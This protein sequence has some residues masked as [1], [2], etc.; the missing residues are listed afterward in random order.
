MDKKQAYELGRTHAD[1]CVSCSQP[2]MGRRYFLASKFP[3]E[4]TL[5]TIKTI[6]QHLAL[7]VFNSKYQFDA[8]NSPEGAFIAY[9]VG[10]CDRIDDDLKILYGPR[11]PN[12]SPA[13]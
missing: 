4:C 11:R 6:H 10:A 5:E 7:F 9:E 8:D 13:D 12:S 3:T 1:G 2:V